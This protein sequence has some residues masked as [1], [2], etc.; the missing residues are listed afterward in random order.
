MRDTR[1]RSPG[2][3]AE[4]QRDRDTSARTPGSTRRIGSLLREKEHA[5]DRD[6]HA[7]EDRSAELISERGGNN[8]LNRERDDPLHRD[9][10]DRDRMPPSGRDRD[11]LPEP[12]HYPH[13]AVYGRQEISDGREVFRLKRS[14]LGTLREIG[15]FR[16][17]EEPD[18]N[19]HRYRG[20]NNRAEYELRNLAKQE[21]IERHS[22]RLSGGRALR[23]A[24]LSDRGKRLLEAQSREVDGEPQRFHAGLVKPAELTHDAALYRVYQQE[25]DRVHDQGGK[26][27]RVVLDY[28]LKQEVYSRLAE[29]KKQA[30]TDFDEARERVARSL[31]LRIVSRKIP[32]PDLRIE[33]ETRDGERSRVDIELATEHYRG[34]QIAAKAQAGFRFYLAGAGSSAGGAVR[35]EREITAEVLSL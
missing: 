8:E 22:L 24:V 11:P 5:R 29:A 21:L 7:E 14:E 23:V 3:G 35:D 33:Y 20:N 30:D 32:L 26:I 17:I 19:R 27:R 4:R 25:A 9:V 16:T 15:S 6:F 1:S 28:E 13:I 18:L 2:S 10:A 34:S 31:E 12:D